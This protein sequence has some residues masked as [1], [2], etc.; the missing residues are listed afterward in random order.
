VIFN[1]GAQLVWLINCR[2][3]QVHIYTADSIE[4]LTGLDD[5]LTGGAVLPGFKCKLRKIFLPASS[6]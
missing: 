1:H 5:T 2:K 6:L 3:Q 4:S